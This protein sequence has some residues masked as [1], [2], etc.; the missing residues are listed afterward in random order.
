MK[1]LV[2]AAGKGE[3]LRPLT[4]TIPKP[5]LELGGRPLIH[6]PLMMLQ[7]AGITQIAVNVYHQAGVIES[8]LGSGQEL[9][10]EIT[11][12]P[13]TILLGTG[14]PLP[15]LRKFFGSEAFIVANSDTVMDLDLPAMI[16][17]HRAHGALATFALCRP[18][19]MSPYSHL[20]IDANGRLR[21]IRLLTG[22]PG[23]SFEDFPQ[24]V[25]G[26]V[27][28]EPY[29]FCGLF[30][31]EPQVFDLMPPAPPFSSMKDIF[32]PMVARGMPL[33]GFV[34]KGLFRTVDDLPTYENLRQEFAAHPLRIFEN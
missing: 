31:C 12:A 28:V 9:G 10:V 23:G 34:H 14:G 8:R 11:Y 2:L 13:E 15:G 24:A 33:F 32:A 21:R 18:A 7:R 16:E 1:A 5:M 30:I 29:M 17:F 26:G 3:R 6:Y 20:E 19:D 4:E 25:P 22:R 27:A